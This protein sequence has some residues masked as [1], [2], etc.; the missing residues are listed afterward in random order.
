MTLKIWQ[1][2][3]S[4]IEETPGEI[5]LQDLK[6]YMP[7]FSKQ[8]L[9]ETPSEPSQEHTVL[10]MFRKPGSSLT[11]SSNTASRSLI[12][13]TSM[14]SAYLQQQQ[15]S[16]KLSWTAQL[17]QMFKNFQLKDYRF[18]EF[19]LRLV[20]ESRTYD[21]QS[22]VFQYLEISRI[23]RIQSQS[24]KQE[25]FARLEQELRDMYHQTIIESEKS[26]IVKSASSEMMSKSYK[27]DKRVDLDR[28]QQDQVAILETISDEESITDIK[29]GSQ[30]DNLKNGSK[31]VKNLSF[32]GK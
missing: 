32:K 31:I 7:G 13:T 3:F 19:Q 15:Q 8:L 6:L 23:T 11:K 21:G 30:Q 20:S 25:H 16:Q 5:P 18:F 28:E 22:F 12:N 1:T 27:S 17:R 26:F 4:Q 9:G 14:R 10:F 24:S 29:K 2:I